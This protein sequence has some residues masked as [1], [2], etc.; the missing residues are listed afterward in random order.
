MIPLLWTLAIFGASSGIGLHVLRWFRIEKISTPE[1]IAYAGAIGLGIGSHGVL[2]IGLLGYYRFLPIAIWWAFLLVL[3]LPALLKLIREALQS[4]KRNAQSTATKP[5]DKD[6]IWA[7]PILI[8]LGGLALF[9]CYLPPAAHEWDA[10]SYH[11]AAPKVYLA[12][13][14]VIFLRYDSHSDFPFLTEML[15][16]S[17]LALSGTTLA[18]MIHYL[19][20]FLTLL[21]TYGFARRRFSS[22]AAWVAAISFASAPIVI[23]EA[24]IAYIELALSLYCAL[25][26]FAYLDWAE[27]Q[28]PGRLWL[29]AAM[30]GFG[31]S[32]KALALIP[33][34]I[35]GIALL[36]KKP[37]LKALLI[38]IGILAAVGSPYYIKSYLL[39]GNPIYPWF[40]DILGGKYWDH[41]MSVAYSGE[42]RSFGL[43]HPLAQPGL[44]LANLLLVPWYLISQPELFYNKLDPGIFNHAGFIF[45]AL[46]A[47]L[48]FTGTE[49]STIRRLLVIVGVWYMAWFFS[50][51]YV[52]YIIP[53]IPLMSVAGGVA[54]T[55]L[56]R[57]GKTPFIV[58]M[59]AI[60]IQSGITLAYFGRNDLNRS[61]EAWSSR[62]R[63]AFLRSHLDD[64]E[65]IEW[66]NHHDPATGGVVIYEDTR[67]FYLNRPYIW[68]NSEHSLYIP[69]STMADGHEL[70]QWFWTHGFR[71]ALIN[72]RFAPLPPGKPKKWLARL[73]AAVADPQAAMAAIYRW[74]NPYQRNLPIWRR[75]LADCIQR[76]YLIPRFAAHGSVVLQFVQ[77]RAR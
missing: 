49:S 74:Y 7:L 38:G 46:P 5:T 19:F 4:K 37:P 17:G 32:V 16:G 34:G 53:I 2:V 6:R 8:L 64:Y 69:Y 68:G 30:L 40:W 56:H 72:L 48:I 20:G 54:T 75:R 33:L 15:L 65:A 31:L 21:G 22:R 55:H 11:L 36:W 14:R 18:D 47:V 61:A 42:Q 35:V 28:Q 50:M 26:V 25:S 70:E 43:V 71:Y 45:L 23:W 3:G 29:I 51:Q 66:L 77:R 63:H 10:L 58:A 59:I 62:A 24:G 60:L 39:T 13:H 41:Q 73:Q 1:R 52:R 57:F 76:G 9:A 44:T 12:H 27:E 67:G